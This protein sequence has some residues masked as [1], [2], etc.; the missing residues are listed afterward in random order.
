MTMK[1]WVKCSS[2]NSSKISIAI[3]GTKHGSISKDISMPAIGHGNYPALS[4]GI[5]Y[6]IPP[7]KVLC[8]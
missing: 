5:S 6:T 1:A 2:I 3:S 7:I 8:K 4:H